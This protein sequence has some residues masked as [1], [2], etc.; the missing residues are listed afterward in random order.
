MK[1]LPD[2]AGCPVPSER[3][4]CSVENGTAPS[5]CP[6]ADADLVAR[7]GETYCSPGISEFARQASIQEGEGYRRSS[8]EDPSPVPCKTRLLEVA[9]FAGRMNFEKLGLV[10]CV[11]LAREARRVR[12]FLEGKGFRVVSVICK[13]GRLP[14][15]KLGVK[16]GEKIRPGTPESMCNPVLQ[17]EVLN[18]AETDFN[19]VMGLCVGHDSIFL[20]FSKAYCT[21][22]AVKDRVTGHNPL[23]AVY[24]LGSYYR[25]LEGE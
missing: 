16:D 4:A 14:K 18:R 15:E 9:E 17:A 21:V 13:A 19:V 2:C 3:R 1:K 12:D 6:T 11:G 25:H 10:F 23:A 22:L 20:R 24:T 7:T 5:G 8:P